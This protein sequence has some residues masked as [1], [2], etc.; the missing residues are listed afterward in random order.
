MLEVS[1]TGEHEWELQ[2]PVGAGKVG[3]RPWERNRGFVDCTL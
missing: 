2:G 1:K 3:L